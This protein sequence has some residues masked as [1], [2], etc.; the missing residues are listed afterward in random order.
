[1]LR[2]GIIGC[3]D[4]ANLNVLGYLY[5]QDTEIVAVSDTNPKNANERL[6]NWGLRIIKIYKDYRVMVDREDLDIVEILTPHNLHRPMTEYCAKA[7][8]KGISVQKPMAHTITDCEK[9]INVCEEERVKLKIYENFRFYPLYLKAKDLLDKGVIGELLNFRINSIMMM[10][11]SMSRDLK[12]IG[13][14]QNFDICGGGP[15]V[16]DDGIHKFSMALWLMGQEQVE[17]VYGWIDY[18]SAVYDGPS[19]IFWKYPIGI[20][21]ESP[22]FGMMEIT[23]A[24]NTYYPSNYY[25]CDEYIEISGTKGLMWINQCTCGGNFISNS[26]QFPP[27]IVYSNG[28]V[29][30]YGNNLPRDWR[31]SFINSTEHF[32]KAI[33]SGGEPIYNGKQGKNLS[34]FAKM[35][36]LSDQ[37]K[38]IIN[39][40]EITSD[41]EENGSCLVESI[42]DVNGA[43]LHK[44]FMRIRKDLNKGKNEGLIQKELKY[45]KDLLL[46]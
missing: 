14:R 16:Y 25:D 11:P 46:E 36:I 33:K 2:V 29:N 12:S 42:K 6:E 9:M 3:G 43:G 8:I 22:K 37:Q 15:W 17:Q 23:L 20:D 19:Y 45:D 44:Y 28:E 1:M 39:W 32:I 26:P 21:N 41:N 31:Y 5:S 24:P 34:I 35:A 10:R 18:F 4:I 40:Q 13:W 27:I 38:R 30:T 7:G